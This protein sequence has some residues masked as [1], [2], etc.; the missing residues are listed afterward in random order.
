MPPS[1]PTNC[2][3]PLSPKELHRQQALYERL[4]LHPRLTLLIIEVGTDGLPRGGGGGASSA[5]AITAG[6]GTSGGFGI[7][8]ASG[9]YTTEFGTIDGLV[10]DGVASVTLHYR[11][12]L[13]RTLPVANNFFVLSVQA[14]IR[15]PKVR[16]G[17]GG[18]PVPLLLRPPFP[19]SKG[20]LGAIAPI[21]IVWR[22][23]SGAVIK[24]VRQPAYCA[25]LHGAAQKRCFL[26]LTV[27][28][29]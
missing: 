5:A 16:R 6:V 25:T 21:E 2:T 9:G 22:D 29:H 17:P 26:A 27:V 15:A 11:H 18:L 24:T 23:A 1:P 12:R 28:P 8:G 20:P 19:P 7:A 13:D 14:R 10:P 3:P 4:R